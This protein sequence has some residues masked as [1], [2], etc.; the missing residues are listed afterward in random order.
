MKLRPDF[1]HDPESWF[2]GFKIDDCKNDQGALKAFCLAARSSA[3]HYGLVIDADSVPHKGLQDRWDSIVEGVH[4]YPELAFPRGHAVTL[5]FQV[6]PRPT[7]SVP[8]EKT[9]NFVLFR[10]IKRP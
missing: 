3:G 2:N 10:I 6:E 8:R 4:S 7:L 1:N 9:Q 5:L